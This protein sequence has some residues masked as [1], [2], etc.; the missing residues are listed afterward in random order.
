MFTIIFFL[1]VINK[2][3]MLEGVVANCQHRH[4]CK[5]PHTLLCSPH[6]ISIQTDEFRVRQGDGRMNKRKYSINSPAISL[7][8]TLLVFS[9]LSPALTASEK[10]NV[11]QHEEN[12][13]EFSAWLWFFHSLSLWWWKI[14][15]WVHYVRY[16]KDNSVMWKIPNKSGTHLIWTDTTKDA[17]MTLKCFLFSV[18]GIIYIVHEIPLW[19]NNQKRSSFTLSWKFF[20][21][22][23]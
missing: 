23:L 18:E 3:S 19:V 14:S 9:D 2:V 11:G 20:G 10:L 22:Y 17:T 6:S 5:S 15:I 8:L 7:P 13:I 1:T 21:N 12:L 4:L 16:L